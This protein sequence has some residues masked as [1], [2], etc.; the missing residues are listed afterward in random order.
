MNDDAKS[1]LNEKLSAVMGENELDKVAGGTYEQNLELLSA[2]SKVDSNRVHNILAKSATA[3]NEEDAQKIVA[4][5]TYGLLKQYFSDEFNAA[6][7]V[8]RFNNYY[9]RDGQKISHDE[10]LSTI[11]NYKKNNLILIAAFSVIDI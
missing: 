8:T 10:V 7:T 5:G 6:V 11:R 4:D 3:G 2:L 9:E 1:K